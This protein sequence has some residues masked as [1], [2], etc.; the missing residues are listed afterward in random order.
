M[1]GNGRTD[2]LRQVKL[3][4]WILI[5]PKIV[6]KGCLA[7][8]WILILEERMVEKTLNAVFRVSVKTTF[9]ALFSEKLPLSLPC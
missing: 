8:N 7:P 5:L 9:F 3:G 2:N 6:P 1:G 4:L